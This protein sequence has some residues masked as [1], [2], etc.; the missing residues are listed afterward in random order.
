M[1]NGL[2]KPAW[3]DRLALRTKP[4]SYLQQVAPL[5]PAPQRSGMPLLSPPRL[6]FNPASAA[7]DFVVSEARPPTI[8][9]RGNPAG[10]IA[11]SAPAAAPAADRIP[12]A[13][14]PAQ[15]VAIQTPEGERK[16]SRAH[17]AQR[18]EPPVAALTRPPEAASSPALRNV[19]FSQPRRYV[20]NAR[21]PS[22]LLPA[23]TQQAIEQPS[24]ASLPSSRT[25]SPVQDAFGPPASVVGRR[26]RGTE[27]WRPPPALRGSSFTRRRRR[28]SWQAHSISLN[29]RLFHQAVRSPCR[30]IK[31]YLKPL[32][33]CSCR[34]RLRL[35]R[36]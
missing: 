12:R 4:I 30:A 13:A 35:D 6:I 25:A 28:P 27:I 22:T 16:T 17:S 9:N 15:T 14:S 10:P 26:Q 31:R 36:Q 19:D 34:R 32:L 18:P 33:R 2:A 11:R 5:P 8:T 3:C 24:P 20:A 21:P 1:S 23:S 29:N 7:P